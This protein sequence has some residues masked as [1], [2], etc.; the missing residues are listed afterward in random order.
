MPAYKHEVVKLRGEL[1]A[2]N[3]RG[4]DGWGTG[5]LRADGGQ[6]HA[7]VG[8]ILAASIGQSVELEGAWDEHPQYG[9][10]LKIKSCVSVVPTSEDGIIAW[11][12]STLPDLGPSRARQ[13]VRRFGTDLW[14]TIDMNPLALTSVDGITAKRADAIRAAYKKHEAE[15]DDMIKL[16][17]WGLTDTQIARCI[18]EWRSLKTIIERI[19]ENPYQLASVVYGFG[20]LRADAVA[21]KAGVKYD[22]PY[23][24]A[25]GVEHVLEEATTKGHCFMPSGALTAMGAKL[26]GV[27]PDLVKTALRTAVRNGRAVRRGARVYSARLDEAEEQCAVALRRLLRRAA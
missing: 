15:R 23:R 16:R 21:M 2:F 17:G 10:R 1:V 22:S 3:M 8:K 5:T 6:Y 25:A 4:S 11:L 7:I 26:L 18:E 27:Q 19:Q 12:V 9:R 13:L 24:V 20:F 14:T